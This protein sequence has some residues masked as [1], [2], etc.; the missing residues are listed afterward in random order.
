MLPA[1]GDFTVKDAS[2][3]I[4]V[5]EGNIYWKSIE[6]HLEKMWSGRY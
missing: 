4:K 5:E 2:S 1:S 6:V 3:Q